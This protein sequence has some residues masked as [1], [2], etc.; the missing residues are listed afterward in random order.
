MV[1]VQYFDYFL[2]YSYIWL[3]IDWQKT[4]TVD[5]PHYKYHKYSNTWVEMDCKVITINV[6]YVQLLKVDSCT[7]DDKS[8]WNAFS[9]NIRLQNINT[10]SRWHSVVPSCL[11]DNEWE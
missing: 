11:Y 2:E 6:F 3:E 9:E 7:N 5:L 4:T 1:D 10:K 8:A